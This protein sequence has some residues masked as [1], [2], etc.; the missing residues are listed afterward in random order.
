M[1]AQRLFDLMTAEDGQAWSL[2]SAMINALMI[3]MST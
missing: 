1:V 2:T 3:G